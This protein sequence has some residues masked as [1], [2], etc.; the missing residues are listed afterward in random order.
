MEIKNNRFVGLKV[1]KRTWEEIKRKAE[2]NGFCASSYIRS[3]IVK[4]LQSGE[5]R[6]K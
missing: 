2:K 4:D 5:A 3:L 6:A 1:N